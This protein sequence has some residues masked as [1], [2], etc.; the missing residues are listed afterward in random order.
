MQTYFLSSQFPIKARGFD[1]GI[2]I[3]PVLP[4]GFHETS[5][6]DRPFAHML[7][8]ML[9]YVVSNTS[10]YSVYRLDGGAHDR[11]TGHGDYEDLATAISHA[12]YL[13]TE[14]NV[15]HAVPNGQGGF[16]LIP[17]MTR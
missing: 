8:W 11:P 9:P 3:D 14:M 4:E 1:R 12:Q 2:F 13:R 15:D 6:E 5:N 16:M 17:Q 10:S 7:F